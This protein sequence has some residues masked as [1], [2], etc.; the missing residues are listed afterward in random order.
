LQVEI[1]EG[2]D[3]DDYLKVVAST[4]LFEGN[5]EDLEENSEYEIIE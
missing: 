4:E 2:E 3:K 5:R 1:K